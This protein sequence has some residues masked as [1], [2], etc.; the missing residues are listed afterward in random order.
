[1]KLLLLRH[2]QAEPGGDLDPGRRL[3]HV[4]EAQA[5]TMASRVRDLLPDA[6]VVT[7]PWVRAAQT[8][9]IIA[10][11]LGR[12][13]M[14][15]PALT[16]E[17][18]INEAA[19]QLETCFADSPSLVVVTHQPLCGQLLSWLTDGSLHGQVV[20]TCSGALL[21]LDWPARAMARQLGWH[22]ATVPDV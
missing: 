7:S 1:M 8:G 2:A 20:A 14:H 12:G 4:G 16:P 17:G 18:K 3:T 9:E 19:E 22:D 5:Q 10:K 15:L 21:E 11:A 6:C 13:V